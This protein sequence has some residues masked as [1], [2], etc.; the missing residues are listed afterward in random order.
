MDDSWWLAHKV[1]LPE[2]Q[3]GN[4]AIER[5]TVRRGVPVPTYRLIYGHECPP[6]TYT[7]LVRYEGGAPEVG[8]TMDGRAYLGG[9]EVM[10]DL[11]G[12]IED[13]AGV[14]EQIQMHGGRILVH[15]LG[16]G[17]IVKFALAQPNVTH[18]D[19]VE[20][21]HDVIDLVAH[22]YA[23]DDRLHVHHGNAFTYEW[24][25]NA[26]WT[27]AWHDIWD[28][29]LLA[30][31]E[32]MESLGQRFADRTRWQGFWSRDYLLAVKARKHL[33]MSLD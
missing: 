29:Y 12:E 21:N 11:P 9:H 27:V 30:N 32:E 6:G 13:H 31:L 23:A 25:E 20:L 7:R 22:H 28:N 1:N 17:L 33:S 18:V 3:V 5:F 8:D 2:G 26:R 4:W 16:L 14:M 15:G 24:P 19:V 10:T